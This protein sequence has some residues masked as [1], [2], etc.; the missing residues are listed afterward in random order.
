MNWGPGPFWVYI[1]ENPGGRLYVGSTD[2]LPRRVAEHNDPDRARSKYTA[3]HRPWTLV[4]AESHSTR[5]DAVQR[6]R[7]IKSRKSAA[8]IRANLLGRASP[9]VHRD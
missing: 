7:F 4:W 5:S 2:D 6:E 8:W 9:D 3:K 1:L